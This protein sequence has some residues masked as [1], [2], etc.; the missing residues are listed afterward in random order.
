MALRIT[1][2]NI[3]IAG[4]DAT[5]IVTHPSAFIGDEI[6]SDA[7]DSAEA[8]V[9][10]HRDEI[11][12]FLAEYDSDPNPK[13]YKRKQREGVRAQT[14]KN[15]AILERFKQEPPLILPEDRKS[16]LSRVLHTVNDDD[17]KAFTLTVEHSHA[18]ELGG[19]F[20][21]MA[22]VEDKVTSDARKKL[23]SLFGSFAKVYPNLTLEEFIAT[24]TTFQLSDQRREKGQKYIPYLFEAE[25]EAAHIRHGVERRNH[26][27]GHVTMLADFLYGRNRLDT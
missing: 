1:S 2:E 18:R 15:K 25:V 6:R 23:G 5:E 9:I 7:Q 26:Y 4:L 21:H 17:L 19:H 8:F 22:D 20:A 3:E 24:D 14:A 13:W 16:F 12:S 11:I 10:E 27:L